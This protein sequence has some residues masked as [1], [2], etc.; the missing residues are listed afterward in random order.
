MA[1]HNQI[2]KH[3]LFLEKL[4]SVAAQKAKEVYAPLLRRQQ[5]LQDN[6]CVYREKIK[7]KKEEDEERERKRVENA[8]AEKRKSNKRKRKKSETLGTSGGTSSGIHQEKKKKKKKE[9]EEEDDDKN[10]LNLTNSY[11]ELNRVRQ[12]I[13]RWSRFLERYSDDRTHQYKN[14]GQEKESLAKQIFREKASKSIQGVR[15]NIENVQR[16]SFMLSV[17]FSGGGPRIEQTY[18]KFCCPHCQTP[19]KVIQRTCHLICEFCKTSKVYPLMPPATNMAYN[20]HSVVASSTGR[21]QSRSPTFLDWI[22]QWHHNFNLIND[23][24]MCVIKW[25]LLQGANPRRGDVTNRMVKDILV[26]RGYKN[27]APYAS[28]ACKMIK[29]NDSN[30]IPSF[31]DYEIDQ[32]LNLHYS[33]LEVF[34]TIKRSDRKNMFNTC[35]QMNK[36]SYILGWYGY[37][38]C[39]PLRKE[40]RVISNMDDMFFII[41]KHYGWPFEYTV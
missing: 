34:D 19:Y 12:R 15:N 35:Y 36:F 10:Q 9:E 13:R 6:I 11:R 27:L 2:G 33:V 24:V 29:S 23:E 28:L 18:D 22:S 37:Q 7:I 40:Q 1:F 3:G 31:S 41:A 30:P 5:T 25:E 14:L 32:Y 17:Q 16:M 8:A 20:D 26:R 38:K 21:S 4:S 39:F